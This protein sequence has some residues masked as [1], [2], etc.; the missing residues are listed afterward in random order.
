[1]SL[2]PVTE[3]KSA[4][5]ELFSEKRVLEYNEALRGMAAERGCAYLDLVEALS[6]ADGYLPT[7]KSTD[8]I[9]LTADLYPAWADYLRTHTIPDNIPDNIPDKA[10]GQTG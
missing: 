7:D 4:E 6:N 9:H 5:G 2:T 1:M 3:K 8:G 10:D